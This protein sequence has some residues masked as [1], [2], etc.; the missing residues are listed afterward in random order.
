MSHWLPVLVHT[1]AHAALGPVLT[2]QSEQVLPAGT[3]VRV[4]L[5]NRE[6]LGVVWDGAA[7]EATGEFDPT[8]VR[9]IA[10]V[11]EGLPPLSAQWQQLLT[12]ASSYYQRSAGEVAL[13]ALPPQLRELTAEQMARRLKRK[14]VVQGASGTVLATPALTPEQA[15]AVARIDAHAGP[16]LLFG[17]TGLSLIH[18]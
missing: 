8:K 10:G 6:T 13:A 18:I 3:L 1:P 2:Y 14:K 7:P 5:G 15:A 9:A 4:P 11:L 12:F 17:A 16:F